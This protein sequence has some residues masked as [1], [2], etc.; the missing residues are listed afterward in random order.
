MPCLSLGTG[1]RTSAAMPEL[2][3]MKL[4]ALR[5]NCAKHRGPELFLHERAFVDCL[6]R[7][8][9]IDRRFARGLLVG[10]FDPGWEARLRAVADAVDLFDASAL[11]DAWEA[12]E[13][14]YDVV[15]AV[16]TLDTVNGLPTALRLIRHAMRA[17]GLFIGALSG[18]N[19]LP[20]LRAAMRA[21]DVVS[22]TASPHA[23]P[24]IEPAALAPLLEQAGFVRPVVDIDRVQ[25]A[26]ASLARLIGDLRAMAATNILLARPSFIG[27][28]A[29]AEA[30]RAFVEAGNGERTLETFEILHFAAWT[31][32]G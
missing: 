24:R 27:R 28:A 23:H 22:G 10:S 29:H 4:R 13:A 19:T 1:H 7:I 16:G 17:N 15:V 25:V 9:L 2:F 20:Q 21:A 5:R 8:V 3:D 12:P 26:Y 6:E 14:A 32:Q 30:E 18:G 11:E 31:P